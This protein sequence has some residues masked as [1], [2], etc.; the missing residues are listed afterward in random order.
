MIEYEEVKLRREAK[1]HAA[2]RIFDA[3]QSPFKG[4]VFFASF[5]LQ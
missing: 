3:Q 5:F 2:T 1:E 4:L